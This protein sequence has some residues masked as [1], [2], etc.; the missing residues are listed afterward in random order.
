MLQGHL[1]HE[2][3]SEASE[4]SD[5]H[6]RYRTTNQQ[7]QAGACQQLLYVCVCIQLVVDTLRNE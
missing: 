5:I 6:A 3:S 2:R 1:L 7:L 4:R